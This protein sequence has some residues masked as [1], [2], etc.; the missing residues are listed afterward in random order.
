MRRAFCTLIL[1][2]ACMLAWGCLR[3]DGLTPVP[4]PDKALGTAGPVVALDQLVTDLARQSGWELTAQ[5]GDAGEPAETIAKA[6]PAQTLSVSREVIVGNIVHYSFRIATGPGKYDRIG[7]HRVVREERPGRPIR[8]R[9][10]LF[11]LHGD[12]KD[13][14][15]MFM[16]GQFSPNLPDDFGVA[17]WLAQHDVDVWG[18]DQGWNFVPPEETDF[19]FFAN[20][21]IQQQ[22]DALD[23]GV[24]VARLTRCVTGNGL[25]K[26]L[27][28]GY[29]S[30]AFTGYGLLNQETQLP[31]CLRQVRGFVA[32]DCGVK[33]DEDAMKQCWCSA[34]D[35]YHSVYAMGQYQDNLIFHDVGVRAKGDPSGA[36]PYIPGL[37]NLQTALYFG[38]G[39]VFAPTPAHYHAGV[40]EDGMPVDLQHVTVPQWLDFLDNM[41]AYEPTR[42]ELE[43]SILLCGEEESP[44]DDHLAEITVP[45]LDIGGAGG[46][47]PHTAYTVSLLGSTDITQ[48]YVSLR[49]PE[50]IALDYGHIDIFTAANAPQLVWQPLLDWVRSH[51]PQGR[52]HGVAQR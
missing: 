45:V 2:L 6:I 26:A 22:V 21:G 15:G 3:D 43:Y 51:S 36:S 30:G 20:W 28:L 38:A 13:F 4:P 12:L 10:W 11:M 1:A 24:A 37:T 8:T 16:P 48:L 52:P 14:E 23:I 47:A 9:T 35:Y 27:V 49:P 29:S 46:L 32:A 31:L 18:M 25:D 40:F 5:K 42:F 39:N 50:E 44:F 17:T 7:I 33:T 41:A 19:S 34:A